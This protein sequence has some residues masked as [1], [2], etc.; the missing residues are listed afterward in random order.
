MRRK[1]QSILGIVASLKEWQEASEASTFAV[2]LIWIVEHFSANN[3][4]RCP[5]FLV[6]QKLTCPD[7][8]NGHAVTLLCRTRAAKPLQRNLSLSRLTSTCAI[9]VDTIQQQLELL[10]CF[11][12]IYSSATILETKSRPVK[13]WKVAMARWLNSDRTRFAMQGI[14][15]STINP[16]V[17]GHGGTRIVYRRIKNKSVNDEACLK[18]SPGIPHDVLLPTTEEDDI[19]PHDITCSNVSTNVQVK[20]MLDMCFG[21]GGACVFSQKPVFEK[22]L[23]NPDFSLVWNGCNEKTNL[24]QATNFVETTCVYNPLTNVNDYTCNH[25]AQWAFDA[26]F[27]EGDR[28]IGMIN[29]TKRF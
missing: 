22:N 29:Q 18:L 1:T 12:T 21:V 2:D 28:V 24:F 8:F 27:G 5:L 11:S 14:N 20:F 25:C 4:I 13:G 16:I 26:Q 19:N 6:S 7:T 9:E 3:I 10:C 15:S 23:L 17:S